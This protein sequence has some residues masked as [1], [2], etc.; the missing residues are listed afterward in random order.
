VLVDGLYL[1][2]LGRAAD[3][4]GRAG[5]VNFL[6]NGGT[7]E[8]AIVILVT[9]PEYNVLAGSP[10]GFVQSLYNKLLG[11]VASSGEIAAWLS[12]LRSL[13]E[14]AVASA[15]LNSSEFRGD[16]V[17]QLY[18]FTPA[19]SASVVALFPNLLHRTASPS[20]A[21]LN[22][23]VSSGLDILTITARIAGSAECFANS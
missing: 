21:E 1:K 7:V 15:F 20:A 4:G 14:S 10:A 11:R 18:G 3:P 9:S 16:L 22:G 6:Q 19:A 13:G 12:P 17:Q 2:L 23:W 8:Q 5:L